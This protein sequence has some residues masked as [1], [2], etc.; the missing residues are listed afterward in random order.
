MLSSSD[1]DDE[2]EEDEATVSSDSFRQDARV[3][4]MVKRRSVAR[5]AAEA[6]FEFE[7]GE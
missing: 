6:V 7:S 5:C 4:T 1:D 2:E 3:V